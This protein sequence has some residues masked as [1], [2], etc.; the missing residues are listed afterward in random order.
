MFLSIVIPIYNDEKFLEE[1]LDSCLDQRISTDE[2]EIVCVDDGSTDRTPEMLKEYEKKHSNIHVILMEHGR[3]SG[4][5]V[6]FGIAKG[7]YIWFVDHDDIVAPGAVDD[8]LA[9]VE[10][11]PGCERV[12][13]PCYEFFDALTE[14]ESERLRNGQL[15]SNDRDAYQDL[16]TWASIMRIDFLK[17]HDICPRSKRID[18]AAR[19]WGIEKFYTWSGDTIFLDEC[20]DKGIQTLRLKGRPLYHY[21]RHE[22]TQTLS[23]NPA[24]V[25]RRTFGK[26]NTG[27]LWGYLA[28]GHRRA[29]DEERSKLGRASQKTADQAIAQVQR[30]V[31]Y[32]MK[33]PS[34][35]W[36]I[37]FK[38]LAEKDIFFHHMPEEYTLS[39]RNYWQRCTKKERLLPSTIANYYL[40]TERGA[41]WSRILSAPIRLL[42]AKG[43]YYNRKQKKKAETLKQHGIGNQ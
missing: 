23:M 9:F 6:G 22:N 18:A 27:L 13:F 29:Y 10:K 42:N 14:E 33:L 37:G 34:K 5:T 36:R 28:Y 39:F 8:L 31:S 7:D 26:L 12:A 11:N 40:I 1:C 20:L 24:M 17:E 21:R 32:L 19:F 4:R 2:Y 43:L 16:A 38:K 15:C 30:A 35:Q 25:R 41:R 3:I